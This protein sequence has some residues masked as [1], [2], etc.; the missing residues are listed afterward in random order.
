MGI[1]YFVN[2]LRKKFQMMELE[3]ERSAKRQPQR[4]HHRLHFE[5]EVVDNELDEAVTKYKVPLL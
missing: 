2:E 1:P 3:R 5:K 4:V